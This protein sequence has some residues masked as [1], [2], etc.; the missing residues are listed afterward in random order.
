MASGSKV[1]QTGRTGEYYVA[2][3]LNRRGEELVNIMWPQNLIDG[4]LML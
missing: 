2:A 1:Q 4:A 3:E